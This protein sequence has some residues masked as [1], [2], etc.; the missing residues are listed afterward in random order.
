M[1]VIAVYTN[2]LWPIWVTFSV[3]AS[4]GKKTEEG[5]MMLTHELLR[6][7]ATVADPPEAKALKPET[8]E[9]ASDILTNC[10]A[11]F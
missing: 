8:T 10:K 3:A 2:A 4:E 1:L 9:R 7:L 11:A 5:T 6:N